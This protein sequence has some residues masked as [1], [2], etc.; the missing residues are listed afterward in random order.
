MIKYTL[1]LEHVTPLSRMQV[2]HLAQLAGSFFSR[3]ILEHKNRTIN[4]KS[5]LGLLSMGRTGIRIVISCVR[6]AAGHIIGENTFPPCPK[7]WRKADAC[8]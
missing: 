5:M 6:A 2:E 4:G 3:V 7:G 1:N 8:G